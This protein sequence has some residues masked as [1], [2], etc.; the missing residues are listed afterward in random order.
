MFPRPAVFLFSILLSSAWAVEPPSL[1]NRDPVY[2]QLRELQP[3]E[4]FVAENLRLEKDAG[5]FVFRNGKICLSPAVLGK[6]TSAVFLGE[7]Q[8]TLQLPNAFPAHARPFARA[9]SVDEPFSE[10]VFFFTDGTD[11]QLRGT[12][13]SMAPE[14]RASGV[15]RS[16]RERLRSGW[17]HHEEIENLDAEILAGLYNPQRPA[18]FRA[19]V[20]GRKHSDLRLAIDPFGQSGLQAP[21]EVTLENHDPE[22]AEGG[23]WYL[24]HLES[25]LKA[26]T[27]SSSEDKSVVK[28]ESYT[29]DTTVAG[30][31]RLAGHCTVGF[32]AL[33]NGERVLGFEITPTLRVSR[34][35]MNGKDVPFIQEDRKHDAAFYV[36]FPEPLAQGKSYSVTIHY[37][38]DKVVRK[39]GG[40]NFWVGSRE[41][42]YP[43]VNSFLD[44]A[45]FDLTFHFPKHYTLVSVGKLDKE[46]KDGGQNASHWISEVPL[47]VAGFNFGDFKK[48]QQDDETTKYSI[49]GYATTEVPDFLKPREAELPTMDDD[50]TSDHLT[51]P[52]LAPSALNQKA[53]VEA[54]VSIRVFS[55]FFGPLPYGRIAI[56]QQPAMFY[57]QSWPTLVYLPLTAYLDAT[58]RLALFR[59]IDARMNAFVDEVTSHEVSH[60]WWGHMVGWKT[61]HDQW[62]SEGFAE[63][64][65]ALFLEYT[66]KKPDK[67]LAFLQHARERLLEKNEYGKSANDAGPVWMGYLLDSAH[68]HAYDQVVYGKGGYVLHM[69]RMMMWD[70]RGGDNA[71]IQMMHD[72][73][74]TYR[75]RS[76]TTEDFQRIVEKH[77]TPSM[78]LAGNGKMDWFFDE[79][80]Y[81]TEIPSYGLDYAL[82]PG[83]GGQTVLKLKLT[84]SGV[85]ARFRMPVPI[86]LDLDG[87][88]TRLGVIRLA[89]S[90]SEEA[91]VNLPRKPARVL[92]NANYDVLSY[93]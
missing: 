46:W 71:F 45:R 22:G 39:A 77:I 33:G 85:G 56:T 57:G 43:N 38:G 72:F 40:G 51:N 75:H 68:N 19:Y 20:K 81:G 1:A 66:G 13:K 44:R 31:D 30:N 84:Q 14:E 64:S 92:L 74:E 93:K 42:W 90:S 28:A 53:I 48:K 3:S 61:F 37:D 82:T 4:C 9:V 25:E 78:D 21:E 91:T 16:L 70:P 35:E 11:R 12:A 65:A 29:I 52:M 24:A 41:S 73:V 79:W 55:H 58:Q 10:A 50:H 5:V 89:G 7:G 87:K 69:L 18:F 49:E 23:I 76:A 15:L 88:M 32:R 54:Q 6:V 63:F 8:F 60:Q 47:P 86:Y 80:V 59:N 83:A 27:A 17:E 2:L 67:Y 34:A 62:L 26:G 36:V